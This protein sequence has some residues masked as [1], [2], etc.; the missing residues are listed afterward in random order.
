M[1]RPFRVLAH[2]REVVRNFTPNWFTVTMGTGILSL[3]LAKFPY[4]FAPFQD[5][6][7]ALWALNLL[8]FAAATV[9]FVARF[10]VFPRA[11][12]GSLLD[13]VESM[14]LGA[15]PMGLATLVNGT[16]SF[17][18]PVAG[19]AAMT[20][21][22]VAWWVDVALSVASGLV[23][24]Y[25]MFTRQDH[26]LDRMTAVWLLPIVP[27]EVAAASGGQV[28]AHV[29]LAAA[30]TIVYTSY[31]LWA[32]SVPL[33][34][35]VLTILFLRM[36][37]HKLPPREMA[38]SGWLTLGPLGTGAFGLL[39]LGTAAERAMRGT[40]LAAFA[41]V[42][43]GAG[44]LG[45]L[46]LWGYGMWWWATAA[47]ATLRS[48]RDGGLPFNMGWWGFT[49]PLGVFTAATLT[50]AQTTGF[51]LFTVLGAL[52]VLLLLGLW[53]LVA[54]R[55]VRGAW[56]GHLFVLPEVEPEPLESEFAA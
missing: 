22:Q 34:A 45:A 6:G 27:A 30:R 39:L 46:V 56:H 26:R 47:S 38:V 13:P 32:L 31:A 51:A 15:I 14:F 11:A 50:L 21:A 44:V 48:V 2:P 36:A 54:A 4:A 25:L 43:F 35:A 33:A 17:A 8:L 40:P 23:V 20:V 19:P 41:S 9:L 52:M 24:P 28:A 12:L 29:G 37:V 18:A 55:T 16:V 3:M 7:R 5:A 53:S 42:A 49:F 1:T 10:V